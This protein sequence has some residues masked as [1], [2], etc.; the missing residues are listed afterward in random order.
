MIAEP[1][2]PTTPTS[3]FARAARRVRSGPRTIAAFAIG[4]LALAAAGCSDS[5]TEPPFPVEGTWVAISLNG[6][7]LPALMVPN[8]DPDCQGIYLVG[9]ELVFE[10][11]SVQMFQDR[12]DWCHPL[13][14]PVP[15]TSIG[16][17][18]QR[19]GRILVWSPPNQ[20][21]GDAVPFEI[22]GEELEWTFT[23][24]VGGAEHV[25][26]VRLEKVSG[27]GDDFGAG[28]A[29]GALLERGVGELPATGGGARPEGMPVVP[30]SNRAEGWR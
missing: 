14:M 1:V 19:G 23:F 25:S 2:R 15:V 28:G 20:T 4:T 3:R 30:F 18:E 10:E 9:I 8:P 27:P 17:W 24:T 29:S 12:E 11:A 6:G 21:I 26:V 5:P 22:R 16:V 13:V 7:P